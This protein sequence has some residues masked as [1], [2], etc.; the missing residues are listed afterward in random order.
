[1]DA[2]EA[3]FDTGI[4][5]IYFVGCFIHTDACFMNTDAIFIHI[6]FCFMNTTAPFIHIETCF[7]GADVFRLSAPAI[8]SGGDG[9]FRG[10]G[11]A[12][13]SNALPPSAL[14]TA[15]FDAGSFPAVCARF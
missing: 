1:M 10:M 8:V 2:T 12:F 3:F 9:S 4:P 14:G 13:M 11:T 15:S 7:I 6:E 5:F